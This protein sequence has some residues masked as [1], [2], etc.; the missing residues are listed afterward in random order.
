[1]QELIIREMRSD[2]AQQLAKI[3]RKAFSFVEGL[4]VGTPKHAMVA[5]RNGRLVGGIM[6]RVFPGAG[7]KAAYISEAFVHP[8]FH[9]Q[10]VGKVL[11]QKTFE[12][13]RAQDCAVL[14]ALVKDDNVASFKLFMQNGFVRVSAREALRVLGFTGFLRQYL[15]TPWLIATGMDLYLSAPG[16][17]EKPGGGSAFAAFFLTNTLLLLP[18]F[19]RLLH[20]SAQQFSLYALA[21]CMLLALFILPRLIGARAS[22]LPYKLRL[23][24]GGSL[25]TLLLGFLGNTFPMNANW[26]PD[27]Y[28]NTDSFRRKLA[29]PEVVKWC[30]FLPLP[31]LHF[32]QIPFLSALAQI[33]AYWLLFMA[34][35]LYPFEAFGAGRVLRYN[36]ILYGVLAALSLVVLLFA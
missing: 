35:P 29:L 17:Q 10:G 30:I 36:K 14:S 15:T 32:T 19:L 3:G 9:G 4:A 11:Y 28:E 5:E 33:S 25:T 12:A 31:L 22:A 13:L 2:E 21:Y 34:L 24:N 20:A 1:M 16:A 8:D 7:Q 6:Y 23:N 26:F 18:L 27:Q